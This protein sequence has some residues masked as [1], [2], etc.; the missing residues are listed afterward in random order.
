VSIPPG[1]IYGALLF[2]LNTAETDEEL[3]VLMPE[4]SDYRK[5]GD[6]TREE[7]A[8]L[9]E[10]GKARR[11]LLAI[12]REWATREDTQLPAAFEKGE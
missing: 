4:I 3:S 11:A 2:R 5:Y 6:L 10:A 7:T 1:G 12:R 9:V 8:H